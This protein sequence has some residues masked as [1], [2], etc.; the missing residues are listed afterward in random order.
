[1]HAEAR[2]AS[3]EIVVDNPQAAEVVVLRIVVLAEAEG[4]V[5]IEPIEPGAAA[6]NGLA[7]REHDGLSETDGKVWPVRMYIPGASVGLTP[8]VYV[9]ARQRG[10]PCRCFPAARSHTRLA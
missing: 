10:L 3:H 2:A 1:M 8:V 4:V 5:A 6:V 9:V 7:N